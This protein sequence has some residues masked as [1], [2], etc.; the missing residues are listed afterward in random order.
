DFFLKK[1][2]NEMSLTEKTAYLRGL[3]DGMGMSADKSDEQRLLLAIVD[4][5][6]DIAANVEANTDAVSA[7]ADELD[8]MDDAVADLEDAVGE[9]AEVFDDDEEDDEDDD[10]GD[11]VDGVEYELECPNCGGPV[12]LDE[13]TVAQGE[14]VCPSCGQKLEI[15]VG[16]DDGEET[17]GDE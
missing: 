5:L 11:M 8:E 14:T 10:A 16:F 17:E 12:Y 4:A 3:A 7:L 9:L 15:D 2:L 6:D 13:E 1:E